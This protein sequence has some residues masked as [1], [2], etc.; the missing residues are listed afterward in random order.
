MGKVFSH[1]ISATTLHEILCIST[2]NSRLNR[3][4]QVIF[5]GQRSGKHENERQ[6]RAAQIYIA[7]NECGFLLCFK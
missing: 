5:R 6:M 4:F 3:A 1:H 7:D 2:K